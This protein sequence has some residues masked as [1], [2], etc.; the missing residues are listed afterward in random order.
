MNQNGERELAAIE[1]LGDRGKGH[2]HPVSIFLFHVFAACYIYTNF[3]RERD[4]KQST[5]KSTT[6][7]LNVGDHTT[8]INC[9]GYYSLP[10]LL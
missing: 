7:Y 8:Q 2:S 9:S 6:K 5:D 1:V 4:C 10:D 3:E